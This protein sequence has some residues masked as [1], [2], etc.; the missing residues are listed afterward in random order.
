[1]RPPASA[2]TAPAAPQIIAPAVLEANRAGG[3]K[4][5]VPDA[6][7]Q[8]AISRS[9]VESVVSTYKLCVSAAG[10]ISLVTQMRSSGFPAYDDKIRSTIRATWRYRPYLVDGRAAPVCTALRFVYAQRQ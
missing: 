10:D 6:V 1:V 9:G 8:E 4:T 7:T 2:A 3:D 5:I